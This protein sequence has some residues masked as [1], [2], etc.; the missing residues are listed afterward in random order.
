VARGLKGKVAPGI[1]SKGKESLGESG[2]Q[3]AVDMGVKIMMVMTSD[4]FRHAVLAGVDP[5][6]RVLG[7]VK[8][9]GE[10]GSLYSVTHIENPDALIEPFHV[11]NSAGGQDEFSQKFANQL[12][13][14]KELRQSFINSDY[15]KEGDYIADS[16]I[17]S[18]R[19]P[20]SGFKKLTS[21]HLRPIPLEEF[22]E[23]QHI[24]GNQ[25]FPD[26]PH[27]F[28]I[29]DNFTSN[30][31]D[32]N[33]DIDDLSDLPQ[34]GVTPLSNS[35][36]PP[37]PFTD[38]YDFLPPIPGGM[39]NNSVMPPRPPVPQIMEFRSYQDFENALKEMPADELV[40][41]NEFKIVKNISEH[42]SITW[43]Y[44]YDNKKH[45]FV[46]VTKKDESFGK[47]VAHVNDGGNSAAQYATKI[48]RAAMISECLGKNNAQHSAQTGEA[49]MQEVRA[50]L[51]NN[52]GWEYTDPKRMSQFL[53]ADGNP[54]RILNS[55]RKIAFHEMK[56]TFDASTPAEIMAL[57]IFDFDGCTY[58][59]DPET[60]L[61]VNETAKDKDILWHLSRRYDEK[62]AH[63]LSEAK[64]AAILADATIIRAENIGE[65]RMELRKYIDKNHGSWGEM[66]T[67]ERMNKILNVPAPLNGP[68]RRRH[69]AGFDSLS[70]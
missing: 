64:R 10:N 47:K 5:C 40:D 70:F 56:K 29:P 3:I 18:Q 25:L 8:V 46:N 42:E 35:L 27:R 4:Q 16:E 49:A 21:S 53:A 60:F 1:E 59:Y 13:N 28:P 26:S 6:R 30:L 43:L 34:P 55:A 41:L 69:H 45:G 68:D 66:L 17:L 51:K 31:A 23:P 48:K 2:D 32:N 44:Q 33:Q 50:F 63:Y 57:G 52:L 14:V 36:P 7:T 39:S 22:P 54:E 9:S 61:F 38:P 19:F 20:N 24:D 37:P 62:V 15:Y 11:Q 12:N 65:A 58:L 67:P